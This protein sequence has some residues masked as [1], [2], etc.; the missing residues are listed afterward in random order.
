VS[1]SDVIVVGAGP[2]GLFVALGLAAVGAPVLV[3]EA[4]DVGVRAEWRGS[5]IHPP[6]LQD[7]SDL[8][9]AG[10]AI[11]GGMRVD[12]IQYRDLEYPAL[13]TFDYGALVGRTPYPF[14]LQFEQYKLL[15]LLRARAEASPLVD[16]CYDRRVVSLTAD[17]DGSI[18]T[19]ESAAGKVDSAHGRWVV[20]ADGAH[21]GV[22]KLAGIGFPGHTYPG[23]S[24]VAATTF[25][26]ERV[27]DD[28]APV[29]YW[30]GPTGRLSLIRTP[31]VWRVAVSVPD[32]PAGPPLKIT[33][34]L[35]R[36]HPALTSALSHLPGATSWAAH[37][38][39]QHQLYRSHQRVAASFR[40]GRVLLVGDAA[41]VTSTTGGM[42]LN[43][44]V[45]DAHELVSRLAPPL[46]AADHVGQERAADGYAHARRE[47]AVATVQPVTRAVRGAAETTDRELRRARIDTLRE[48]AA[49]P[50]R[51]LRHLWEL[52]MFDSARV[53]AA[54][55]ADQ[56]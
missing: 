51:Q 4:E 8:D 31:D 23:L 47:A 7:L 45:H 9:V 39:Q 11:A 22:R 33:Y 6:T 43:S 46:A 15:R 28:L 12:R 41:H 18:V 55:P 16:L 36:P 30:T 34:G 52:S 40:S 14:R 3:L 37:P 50:A 1:E 35:D 38:L 44:G 48:L 56:P 2:V 13:A 27:V 25:P 49:D 42:G 26:F 10:P 54:V 53:G 29:S 5:T 32:R 19:S 24:L 20:G 21:S 17:G